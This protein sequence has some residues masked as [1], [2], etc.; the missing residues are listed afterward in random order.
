MKINHHNY[1]EYFILYMDNELT[2]EDRRMVEDFVQQHPHL[3]EELNLLLQYK[4]VPDDNIVYPAKEELIQPNGSNTINLANYEEWLVRYTDEE[5]SPEQRAETEQFIKENPFLEKELS[6]LAKTRLH[7]E[8]IVFPDKSSLYRK[9]ENV[10]P[11]V[12]RWW[13]IAAAAILILGIGLATFTILNKRAGST[14]KD[15]MAKKDV[16]AKNTSEPVVNPETQKPDDIIIAQT[17]VQQNFKE[18]NSDNSSASAAYQA[19]N[20]S[21]N[22]TTAADNNTKNK[23]V[24]PV[25]NPEQRIEIPAI[26][27]NNTKNQPSNNLPVPDEN[28]YIKIDQPKNAIAQNNPKESVNTENKNVTNKLAS[29]S[30]IK[31]ASY[32]DNDV[33]FGQPDGKKNKL[34]GFFRKLTRTFEKRTDIDPTDDDD[35]LLVAGLAIKLK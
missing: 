19:S 35:K 32:N 25:I 22:E 30:D 13:R 11:F 2:P 27:D 17:P 16:P 10:R 15:N 1:E 20:K 12:P 14:S 9:E 28:P 6:L 33:A 7:P 34:R 29:P 3:K 31:Q 23:V 4:L 5:L 21:S 26:A 24:Q 8:E 18:E